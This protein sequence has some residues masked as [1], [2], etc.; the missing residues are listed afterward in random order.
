MGAVT[1][2]ILLDTFMAVKELVRQREVST[3]GVDALKVSPSG[4]VPLEVQNNCL[5]IPNSRLDSK[6]M[7][8]K[9]PKN[10]FPASPAYFIG[11]DNDIERLT[12]Y[13]SSEHSSPTI[14]LQGA[15]GIGK[16][17]L[18]IAVANSEQVKNK[19]KDRRTFVSLVGVTSVASLEA[20]VAQAL[21][22]DRRV[23]IN[24]II[25]FL[26]RNPRLL[27]LDNLET[28]WE[29]CQEDTEIFLRRISQIADMGIIA[30][31]RGFEVIRGISW[32]LIHTVTTLKTPNDLE[33][34]CRISGIKHSNDKHL[35][36]FQKALG[37][38][39]LAIWL[40]ASNAKPDSLPGLW[41]DWLQLGV[42]LARDMNREADAQ[43][44]LPHSIE[45]SVK[46][47]RLDETSRRLFR[48]LGQLPA[49]IS[50][51][52]RR[53][54]FRDPEGAFA[55]IALLG[56]GLAFEADSRLMMLPPIREY[57]ARK[58]VPLAGDTER[59]WTDHYLNLVKKRG[60]L[61]GFR[62]GNEKGQSVSAAES[63][64]PEFGN[65]ENLITAQIKTGQ[66][67]LSEEFFDGFDR[68]IKYG[69][70]SG[71]IFNDLI[72]RYNDINDPTLEARCYRSLGES[73]LRRSNLQGAI[74]SYSNAYRIYSQIG[75]SEEIAKCDLALGTAYILSD[76][77]EEAAERL[78]RAWKYFSSESFSMHHI[79]CLQ[80]R[81]E[82]AVRTSSLDQANSLFMEA[83][84]KYKEIEYI[85]GCADCL[86][87]LGDVAIR[88]WRVTDARRY[89]NEAKREYELIGDQL[90]VVNCDTRIAQILVME[91]DYIRA[92]ERFSEAIIH[93]RE[94]GNILGEANCLIDIARI[95]LDNL[96]LDSS[97]QNLEGALHLFENMK[98]RFGV[99]MCNE[100]FSD[101]FFKKGDVHSAIKYVES[102]LN[103]YK[104]IP[105]KLGAANCYLRI[106]RIRV[107]QG[108]I[109]EARCL[110]EIAVPIF[111][112]IGD[113]RGEK[114][115]ALLLKRMD[116]KSVSL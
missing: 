85:A 18:S 105:D 114:E 97:I 59:P 21:S 49:G 4:S 53:S 81:A 6:E 61:I 56:A 111:K 57:A 44:S 83:M 14:L 107:H 67:T 54:L 20:T 87:G 75:S 34:F 47:K 89:Y 37:G 104:E 102:A 109:D 62:A 108:V 22:M 86:R 30:S 94:L 63:L 1:R 45:L 5:P 50:I 25:T 84:S 113:P 78:N 115:S 96:V 42:S 80:R 16:T 41:Q 65:I 116:A 101:L 26:K 52:D 100:T 58:H 36:L 70:L 13:L 93:Y 3:Q 79:E 38:L 8:R 60:N 103:I 95:E 99:A 72:R 32:G 98:S 23:D 74:E 24:S 19:F 12:E 55:R 33:L 51:S 112:E 31:F 73:L 77:Q 27:V 69:C 29:H 71:E 64:V 2:E 68:I 82:M 66:L 48:I 9:N 91:N 76:R 88:Q 28:P 11:R 7:G 46:S 10:K 40:V 90:R 17:A 43:S 92:R 110:V 15:P 39:P 106:A 35:M